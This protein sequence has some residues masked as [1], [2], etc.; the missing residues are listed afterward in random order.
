MLFINDLPESIKSRILLFTDDLKLIAN[1]V[2]KDIIGEDL[3]SLERLEDLWHLTFNLEKCK[4]LHISGN[5]NPRK[6]YYLDGTE[7]VSTQS[8]HG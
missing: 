7:L 8:D 5:D 3:K 1:A 6:S 2:N 4:A